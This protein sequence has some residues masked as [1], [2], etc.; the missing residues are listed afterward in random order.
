MNSATPQEYWI[1]FVIWVILPRSL[2]LSH[3]FIWYGTWDLLLVHACNHKL[4]KFKDTWCM[5]Q[6]VP[7]TNQINCKVYYDHLEIG[8]AKFSVC[9]SVLP[10]FPCPLI[11][12]WPVGEPVFI[13][14]STPFLVFGKLRVGL[15]FFQ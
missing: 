6:A 2:F 3:E 1:S 12:L 9:V 10:T 11:K 14:M 8:C 15:K 7:S 4:K 5:Q 13:C